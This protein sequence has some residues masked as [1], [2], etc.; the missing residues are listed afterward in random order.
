MGHGSRR[1]RVWNGV[2]W[3]SCGSRSRGTRAI[4]SCVNNFSLHLER[5]QEIRTSTLI[6]MFLEMSQCAFPD[7]TS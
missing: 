1:R 5:K 3:K 6:F 7:E 2:G 4:S